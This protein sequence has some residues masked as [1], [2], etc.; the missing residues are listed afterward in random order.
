M[1]AI[2]DRIPVSASLPTAQALLD[3]VPAL[4]DQ[5]VALL[6]EQQARMPGHLFDQPPGERH[7]AVERALAMALGVLARPAARAG[8]QS[9]V[10]QT[11]FTEAPGPGG[12]GPAPARQLLFD[13]LVGEHHLPASELEEM[14]AKAGW[15]SLPQCIQPIALAP[16]QPSPRLL[17]QNALWGSTGQYE[18]CC[19]IPDPSPATQ[20]VLH[21]S[22]SGHTAAV[23]PVVPLAE[24][25]SALRWA[26]SL[27]H[28][29]QERHGHRVGVVY[30][31]EHL[32]TLLLMQD[33]LLSQALA[34]QCLQP[35]D[36]LP[37]RR[38][39]R[40]SS[41]LLAWLQEGSASQAAQALDVH[42]QT[43]RYRM[44]Q[45]E[46]LFGRTLREPHR[47]FELELALHCR[48]LIH[49]I[50]QE[51]S[52]TWRRA[53]RNTAPGRK[54]SAAPPRVNGR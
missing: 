43:I 25:G 40:L 10:S 42:P 30:V 12:N 21:A 22:L 38:R 41:T 5:I 53:A 23:G 11:P 54:S 27:L 49:S 46:E 45:I 16:A 8:N 36:D 4:V 34:T 48:N 39:E 20:T 7:R 1:H 37:R 33:E 35:L 29:S 2:S 14:G 24:A 6:Q 52:R 18:P 3:A 32:T 44:R 31:E 51:R 28:L 13:A 50:R 19:L 17:P 9:A 47:R 26:R 15:E